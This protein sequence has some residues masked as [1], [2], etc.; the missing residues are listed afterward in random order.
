MNLQAVNLLR[1]G[2]QRNGSTSCPLQEARSIWNWRNNLN[3]ILISLG[4]MRHSLEDKDSKLGMSRVREQAGKRQNPHGLG[5][6]SGAHD[7]QRRQSEDLTQRNA[8]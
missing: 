2:N 7:R 3:L 1:R 8:G 4:Q 5:E 6:L